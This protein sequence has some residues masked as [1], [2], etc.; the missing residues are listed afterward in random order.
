[1]VRSQIAEFQD[2]VQA[3]EILNQATSYLDLSLIY[4]NDETET[5]QIRL[6]EN[7]KFRMGKNN[8]LPVDSNGKYLKSMDRFV[9]V[10]IASVWPALFARNHNHL[11]ERLAILN[12]HWSDEIVFQEARRINIAVFQYNLIAAKSIERVFNKAVNER[13]SETRNAGVFL[14]FSYAYRGAHYYIPS[15]MVFR[16]ENYTQ[17][18]EIRFSDTIRKINLLENDFDGVLRGTVNQYVNTGPYS[19][20]VCYTKSNAI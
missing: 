9:A 16:D 4:G 18:K 3:G 14:E 5:K 10:P 11:A 17:T 6:Y 12:P 7:G 19:D 1:M 2:D 13:Y 20:E 8:V 15:D